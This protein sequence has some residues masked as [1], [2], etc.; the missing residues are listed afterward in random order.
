[1]K[2]KKVGNY[3]LHLDKPLGKGNLGQ[4]YFAVN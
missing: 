4:T 2:T 3:S 1:M